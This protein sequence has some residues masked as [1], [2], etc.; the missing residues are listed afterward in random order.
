M[1]VQNNNN[2]KNKSCYVLRYLNVQRRVH[3]SL[4]RAQASK[5]G[6]MKYNAA[7]PTDHVLS[8]IG[9][10]PHSDRLSHKTVAMEVD[11]L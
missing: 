5:H 8:C 3:S 1:L 11:R 6:N 4:N 9:L 7:I 10:A 2:E